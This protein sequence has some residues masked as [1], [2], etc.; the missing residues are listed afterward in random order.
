[1]PE[2][3]ANALVGCG[4]ATPGDTTWQQLTS[5]QRFTLVK[6]TRPGHKNA[7]LLAALQEFGLTNGQK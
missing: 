4:L 5:L 6:L 1:V 3:V 2:Q 7:N